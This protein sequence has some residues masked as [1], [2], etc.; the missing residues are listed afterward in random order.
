MLRVEVLRLMIRNGSTSAFDRRVTL[1]VGLD[2]ATAFQKIAQGCVA[3]IRTNHSSACAGNP[4]GLHQ[5]RIAITRLRA[6]VSFFAPIAVDTDWLRLK[7]ELAWLNASLGAARDSDVMLEYAH[8]KRYK[9]WAQRMIGDNLDRRRIRGQR[10]IVRCLRSVRL[11]RLIEGLSGWVRY[12]AWREQSDVAVR[13]KTSEPLDAYCRCELNRWRREVIRKGRH[14][15]TLDASRRHRL[16]IKAKRFRYMLEA[17]AG[18]VAAGGRGKFR[19][20]L[21]SARCLQRTLG[22]LRDLK[23]FANLGTRLFP[24]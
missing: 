15:K 9:A 11:Q 14:L 21:R 17:L 19:H 8:R 3:G 16:R 24:D 6:A 22:D 23:H 2:S 1:A 10:Q 13:R 4:K 7:K 12:G 5:I 20:V 18:I